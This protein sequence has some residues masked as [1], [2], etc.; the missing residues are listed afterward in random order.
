MEENLGAASWALTDDEVATL[1]RVSAGPLP[2]PYWH[3]QRFNTPRMGYM[4]S[5]T[6]AHGLTLGFRIKD[7]GEYA[8]AVA[9]TGLGGVGALPTP[10]SVRGLID[11]RRSDSTRMATVP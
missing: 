9:A 1:D 6:Y 4:L 3:Q 10:D 7:T 5:G 2:Y 8:A 11:A